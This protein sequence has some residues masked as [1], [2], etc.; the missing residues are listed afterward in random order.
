MEVHHH[1]EL[2]DGHKKNFKE[3]LKEGLMIFLAVFMGFI[4]ENIREHIADHR[5]EKEYIG[6]LVR[7]LK[8]DSAHLNDV[9]HGNILLNKGQDSLINLLSDST[10]SPHFQNEAYRLFFKYATSLQVFNSTDRTITQM[11]N[12]G[13]LR[14]IENQRVADSISNYYDKVKEFGIQ[15]TMDNAVA[16]DCFMFAQ[17]LFKFQYGLKPRTFKKDMITTN[18]EMINKYVNKL[19]EMRISEQYYSQVDLKDLS[20]SCH[21]LIRFLSSEYGVE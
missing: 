10:S 20:K 7:D 5:K 4:A 21:N 1:P 11:I 18:T 8:Q 17:N 16:N 15:A 2:P 13:N 14:L 6:S 19:T 9:I 3:Y 12:S